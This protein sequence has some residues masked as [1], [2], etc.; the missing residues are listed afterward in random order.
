M[1]GLP[2]LASE[3]PES[4]WTTPTDQIVIGKDIMELLS[5]SMYV[6]PMSI[7]REYVQNAA[8]AIDAAKIGGVFQPRERGQ[9]SIDIDLTERLVRIRD[10]G[11]GIPRQEFVSRLTAFGASTKR[12]STARGFRGVGRL[13]GIGYCQQVVFRSRSNRKEEVSELRWDCRKLK[14]IMNSKEFIG[15]LADLVRETASV[16]TISDKNAPD[17]FFEVE[18]Q[19]IVR[20]KNDSLLDAHAIYNYLSQVAPVPFSP[21]FRYG[22]E[23]ESKLAPYTSLAN[24]HIEIAGRNSPV[25][26]P[27][28]NEFEIRVG[29]IDN[30]SALEFIEIPG[31]E[32]NL[33]AIGWVLH[34]G[35]LG[36]IPPRVGI[37]GLRFRSGNI[38]IGSTNILEEIFPE[39]RFNAW[40]V[41]EL[42]VIDSRILPNGRRDHFEQNVHFHNVLNHMGPVVRA[43][44]N[45]ARISSVRRICLRDLALQKQ[46]VEEKVSIIKQGSLAKIERER[47]AQEIRKC[48]DSMERLAGRNIL[49]DEERQGALRDIGKLRGDLG[50][51]LDGSPVSGYLSKLSKGKR[52]TYQSVFAMIYECAPNQEVAK[53]IVDR[54]LRRIR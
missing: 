27:H 41:G 13:A 17:H 30:F 7:Y 43:I 47:F 39:T 46:T 5:N 20:H 36:A 31:S 21:E 22:E 40:A 2:A 32:N 33:A 25:Y 51:V 35:Y 37:S 15:N 26:R 10:N 49:T 6:D 8:D 29:A 38:Q 24:L 18:L 19:G 52:E 44:S 14:S 42:H 23:I 53:T 9:V 34:H 54:I 4:T 28:R 45:R 48:M 50:K 1:S 3:K 11:T 16:R 12:G